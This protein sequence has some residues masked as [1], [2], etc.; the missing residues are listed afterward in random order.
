MLVCL[1]KGTA[2]NYE[3]ESV[4]YVSRDDIGA[5]DTMSVSVEVA[6]TNDRFIRVLVVKSVNGLCPYAE[7]MDLK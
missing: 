7:A 6:D 5:N 1:M 3:V 4:N 2:D